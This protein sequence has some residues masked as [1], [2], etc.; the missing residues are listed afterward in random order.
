[1]FAAADAAFFRP[2][3]V[4]STTMIDARLAFAESDEVLIFR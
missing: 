1:M 2:A 4:V 3:L